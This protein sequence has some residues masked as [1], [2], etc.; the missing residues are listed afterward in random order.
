MG[1]RLAFGIVALAACVLVA[2][3]PGA[4]HKAGAAPTC[5]PFTPASFRGEVPTGHDV[6][7][8]DLGSQEVTSAE[9]DTYV[10]AVDAA[11]PRVVSGVF[12]HS[13]EG[14][15]LTYAIV[16]KPENVTPSGLA[17]VQANAR[18]LMDPTTSASTAAALAASTPA[19]LWIASNVHGS[20][21]S[22]TDASLEVLYELADRSDCAAARIL[23]NAIVVIVPSQ[24]PD[25][26]EAER[27]QNA[28]GFD[29]NRDWFARTQPETD[30]KVELVKRYPPVLFIDDH[31]MGTNTFFFP[32]NADPMYHEVTDEVVGWINNIYGASMQA[33]FKRQHIP[34]F[35][36]R[37]YDFFGVYYGDTVPANGFMAAGMTFEKYSGDKVPIRVREQ[38]VAQWTSI[39]QAAISK[40][41]ILD[42]WH[43]AWAEAL[44]E[45]QAGQLEPNTVVNPKNAIE[46]QVPNA[47]V[48]NYFIRNDDSAKAADV[49]ALVR[50][51]QRMEVDVYRLTAPLT[52][53]D[54]HPYGRPVTATTL[55]TGTYWIPLAQ[56]QKHWVQA[57]L[58]ETTYPP[59]NFFYDVSA[60]SQPLLFN[61]SGGYSGAAVTPSA[62]LE[63]PLP[64]PAPPAL[65]ANLPR[66]GVLQTSGS[67]AAR[68]SAGWLRW[69]FDEQWHVPFQDVTPAQIAAGSLDDIDVLIATNGNAQVATLNL[70]KP[71][72]DALRAW[73]NQ[74]GRFVG[75]RGGTE[76]AARL[77]LTTARLRPAHSDV[78]GSL[79]RVAVNQSS[80]LATGVGLYDWALYDYDDVMT[81]V[82]GAAPVRYP[83][84]GSEDF[85]VSGF[86]SGENELGG[87]AAVADEPV[88]TGRLVLF[89]TDPNYRAWTQGMQKILWNAL[90]GAD[91]WTGSAPKAGSAARAADEAAAIAA[92]EALP[93]QSAIK[94]SVHQRDADQ[95]KALIRRYTT[96]Y[97]VAKATGKVTYLIA[98]PGG[99]SADEHPF[100][101]LLSQNLVDAGI[102]P[103]ALRVP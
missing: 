17:A 95:T 66:I 28:Y 68:E 96:N 57:M 59:V 15:P 43:E 70:G 90:F 85:F 69:L 86:A 50:R 73:V 30:S 61:V 31:E 38:Y 83:A 12:G 58:N 18:T 100:I 92:A 41:R 102:A 65:P 67:T 7:G 25:G 27:R 103:V 79:F 62:T 6:L 87:T 56:R 63:P 84:F 32:P 94:L 48:R 75:I 52:V 80:P 42:E 19:I 8:F 34:F 91:P 99:L 51:L 98:N 20:E 21:E 37:T 82:D 33:E 35:N 44:V 3:A 36:G 74:G 77:G 40:E 24:N 49:K 1:G 2:L 71:G 5:D 10:A 64:A 53:S 4:A 16:G 45:G 101:G 55:P 78:P 9:S 11:S 26:R 29:M 22:G 89:T 97:T 81:I 60:W 47:P 23:D 13:V 88:G 76:L 46:Q 54:F 39:S 14:R 93:D 72:K